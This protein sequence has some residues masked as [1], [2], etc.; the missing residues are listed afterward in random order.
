ME[1]LLGRVRSTPTGRRTAVSDGRNVTR[2]SGGDV[3]GGPVLLVVFDKTLRPFW[4]TGGPD[5]WVKGCG[6]EENG[7]KDCTHSKV[8]T[9]LWVCQVGNDGRSTTGVSL[10]TSWF[11]D[12]NLCVI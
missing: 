5:E 6:E 8:P 11:V 10:F 3:S 4:T 2:V 12:K 1:S 9:V 7:G